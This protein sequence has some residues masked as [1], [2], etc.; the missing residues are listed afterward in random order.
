MRKIFLA[1]I[2][3][4]AT[5]S[6]AA[7]A[8][9]T[10]TSSTVTTTGPTP[11]EVVAPV[12]VPPAVGGPDGTVSVTHTEQI[13]QPDG[14][15]IDKTTTHY[16]NTTSVPPGPE[17]PVA[18]NVTTWKDTS[19]TTITPA[20]MPHSCPPHNVYDPATEACVVK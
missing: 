18:E 10:T 7:M 20:P 8:Q 15:K 3:A 4:A 13:I 17:T 2:F 12:V 1:A 5:M 11:P 14:T 19:S 16:S 9:T 6:G